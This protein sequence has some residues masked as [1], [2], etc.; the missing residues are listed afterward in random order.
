MVNAEPASALD[1][2]AQQLYTAMHQHSLCSPIDSLDHDNKIPFADHY[3][4]QDA[5]DTKAY[6]AMGFMKVK[7]MLEAVELGFHVLYLDVDQVILKHPLAHIDLR[8]DVAAARDC[9]L[10]EHTCYIKL[11]NLGVIYFRATS[12]PL[13]CM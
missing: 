10:D 11:I 4:A 2:A 3:V 8:E 13:V 7:I 6:Q 5:V 1:G 12:C 9:N